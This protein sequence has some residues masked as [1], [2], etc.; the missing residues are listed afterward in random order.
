MM[1]AFR[2]PTLPIRP[3][4][5]GQLRVRLPALERNKGAE[6]KQQVRLVRKCE[7][8][9]NRSRDDRLAADR[10]TV[11]Q[12]MT[13][14]VITVARDASVQ[15]VAATMSEHGVRH[16]LVVKKSGGL[17]GIISDRD[18]HGRAGGV[19]TDIMTAAP[20][21]VRPTTSIQDAI[22]LMVERHISCIPVVHL[23]RL[24]GVV[25]TV[26]LLMALQ[27]SLSLLQQVAAQ[28]ASPPTNA[29]S[30]AV[31]AP[32]PVEASAC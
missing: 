3:D 18:V 19:A 16:V 11:D 29:T 5:P 15:E 13:E 10:I 25:T 32:V 27:G 20:A 1:A 28:E 12:V 23:Y 21:T 6:R 30:P 4:P 14:Q 17:A 2:H 24:C 9:L 8:M 7:Q 31:S 26:D 22:K